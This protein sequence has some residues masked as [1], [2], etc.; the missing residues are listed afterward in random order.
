MEKQC[1]TCSFLSRQLI[2][3]LQGTS[4]MDASRLADS[5]RAQYG[6]DEIANSVLAV[7]TSP[8]SAAPPT[9]DVLT[10]A[11]ESAG[12]QRDWT[13]LQYFSALDALPLKAAECHESGGQ[14]PITKISADKPTDMRL[15]IPLQDVLLTF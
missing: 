14:A 6:D 5:R 3:G 15:V 10:L 12:T 7:G 2:G 13:L 9:P 1:W 11:C 8:A 4:M